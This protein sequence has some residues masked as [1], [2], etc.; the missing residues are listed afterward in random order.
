MSYDKD[1]FSQVHYIDK[2]V[3]F[4]GYAYQWIESRKYNK[5]E[6]FFASIVGSLSAVRGLLA[7]FQTGKKLQ[8]KYSPSNLLTDAKPYVEKGTGGGGKAYTEKLPGSKLYLGLWH[9]CCENFLFGDDDNKL[10]KLIRDR[11][12]IPAL[13]EWGP[14]IMEEM[15]NCCLITPLKSTNCVGCYLNADENK[16]DRLVSLMIRDGKLSF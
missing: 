12:N 2:G 11:F 10:F 6:V 15:R 3:H 8:R 13:P 5:K 4:G 14:A 7:A 1:V 9:S 16:V